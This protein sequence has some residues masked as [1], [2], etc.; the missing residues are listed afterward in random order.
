M[1]EHA[2]G[3]QRSRAAALSAA[4]ATGDCCEAS[5]EPFGRR[6]QRSRRRAPARNVAKQVGNQPNAA[7]APHGWCRLAQRGL[8]MPLDSCRPS[9][10]AAPWPR[11][12]PR[13][14][15]RQE[16]PSLPDHAADKG[17]TLKSSR[18]ET[19]VRAASPNAL[20]AREP[21]RSSAPAVLT[22]H[23]GLGRWS[24]LQSWAYSSAVR[25]TGS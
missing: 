19:L 10:R 14:V 9:H 24:D 13:L 23:A 5:L 4:H 2:E 3:Q 11:P 6:D 20:A 1:L 21:H 12:R 22:S 8:V 7:R 18:S 16:R 15:A 25:A 17:F